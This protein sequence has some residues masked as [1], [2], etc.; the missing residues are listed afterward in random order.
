MTG[1]TSSP[2]GPGG[3][4]VIY[5]E[6][7]A[8]CRRC[9]LWLADQATHVPLRFLAAGSAD[10]RQRYGGSWWLGGRADCR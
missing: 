4:T 1:E 7:C 10:A 6:R 5:D 2:G 3:M 8:F 9:R